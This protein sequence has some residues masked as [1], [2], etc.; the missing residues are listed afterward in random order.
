MRLAVA[1]GLAA[2]LAIGAAGFGAYQYLRAKHEVE[3]APP[4]GDEALERLLQNA[5]AFLRERAQGSPTK[6]TDPLSA[7]TAGVRWRARSHKLNEKATAGQLAHL[8]YGEDR[9]WPIVAVLNEVHA[10]SDV[11]PLGAVNLVLV[12]RYEHAASPE[13]L[14]RERAS[15]LTLTYR[16]WAER[17]KRHEPINDATIDALDSAAKDDEMSFSSRPLDAD[18]VATLRNLAAA[19]YHDEAL[20]PILTWY[21]QAPWFGDAGVA[22]DQPPDKPLPKGLHVM[23]PELL[24]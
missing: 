4:T 7:V 2:A 21:N 8:Y 16:S 9:F 17:A 22:V 24:P 20:W 19:V 3:G 1:L 13:A 23:A 12:A 10:P 14:W 5:E 11:L 15:D 6:G 18:G